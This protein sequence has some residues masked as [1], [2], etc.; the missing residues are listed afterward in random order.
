MGVPVGGNTMIRKCKTV[1]FRIAAGVLTVLCVLTFANGANA[2]SARESA[3]E[4]TCHAVR[5]W[6]SHKTAANLDRALTDSE[7]VPWRELGHDVAS[8]YW[9]VRSR[10]KP[11]YIAWDER[12]LSEDCSA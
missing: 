10:P 4:R 7:H 11:E 9:D 5:A 1:A 6:E 12:Y 8:L 2:A 3:S